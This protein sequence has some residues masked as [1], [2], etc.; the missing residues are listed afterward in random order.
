LLRPRPARGGR[1]SRC[2]R[3]FEGVHCDSSCFGARP[4]RLPIGRR[5]ARVLGN[6]A[7]TMR[8]PRIAPLFVAAFLVSVP[9]NPQSVHGAAPE[10]A[11]PS[12]VHRAHRTPSHRGHAL[13]TSR[14]RTPIHGKFV[15]P[16]VAGSRPLR[17]DMRRSHKRPMIR[18]ART[19][20]P[21]DGRPSPFP[22]PVSDRF[23]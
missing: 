10:Q 5:G 23:Q 12:R 7:E 20:L 18:M 9:A 16:P 22:P 6:T 13:E 8:L 3:W 1:E 17:V 19:V 11:T 4:R 15:G 2:E 21:G 14:R